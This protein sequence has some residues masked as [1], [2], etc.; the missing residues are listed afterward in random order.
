MVL[1]KLH[2]NCFQLIQTYMLFV[3]LTLCVSLTN[4]VVT[5][6]WNKRS[7]EILEHTGGKKPNLVDR[8]CEGVSY[9][10]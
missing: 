10:Y 3:A 5:S 4:K 2:S 8:I 9:D 7:D 6:S 1:E